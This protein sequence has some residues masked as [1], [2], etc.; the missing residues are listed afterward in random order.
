MEPLKQTSSRPDASPPEEPAAPRACRVLVVDDNRGDQRLAEEAIRGEEF[1]LCSASCGVEALALIER[2]LPDVVLLDL[3]LPDMDGVEV[4]RRIRAHEASR[5]LPVIIV[6]GRSD[7]DDV[8]GGLEHGANDYIT[9]PYHP[10][11]ARARIRLHHA[12]KIGRDE[13]K[14]INRLKDEF[15]SVASHDL[16]N[17][18]STIIGYSGWLLEGRAGNLEGTTRDSIVRIFKNATFM[19]E[20]IGDLLDLLKIEAGRMTIYPERTDLQQV[21]TEA[22]ERNG[23]TAADKGISLRAT[24]DPRMPPLTADPIKLQQLLNNLISN[25]IKFSNPGAEVEVRARRAPG[26][27]E[28]AVADTGQGIPEGER[29]QLFRKWG[30]LSVRATRGEKSTGLGL[31]IA[32]KIVDLHGGRIWVES[33]VG[34]GSTFHVWLPLAA[35]GHARR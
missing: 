17:P 18:V 30:Q 3:V 25:G 24:I 34:K 2:A 11:I 32:K 7:V 4:L 15:L 6:T 22:I 16:Q 28:L 33:E 19:K 31:M 1:E 5:D 29:D 27:V 13:L 8:V 21:V 23:F 12:A 35:N 10:D 14:R 20:L 9:K 26:G